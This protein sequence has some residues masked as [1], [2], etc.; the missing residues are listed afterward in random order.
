MT[1][2]PAMIAELRR[3]V[4][5]SDSTTYTD[6]DL[7]TVIARFPGE[8]ENGQPP[9]DGTNGTNPPIPRTNPY[10][11]PTYDINRAAAEVWGEKAADL[12][13]K[14]NISEDGQSIQARQLYEN[15]LSQARFWQARRRVGT[16][17]LITAP[18]SR[19]RN[20]GYQDT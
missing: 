4:A 11:M 13:C 18:D 20:L 8:D 9:Y 14:I 10:W 19:I 15:A 5:E 2:T 1:V 6:Y 17:E 3:K 12:Y 7:K 16:V